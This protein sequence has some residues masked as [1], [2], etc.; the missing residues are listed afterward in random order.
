[1]NVQDLIADIDRGARPTYFFFWGHRA[2]GDSSVGKWCLSQ[3]WLAPFELDGVGYASAEHFM[4]AGKARL[5]GDGEALAAI[6]KAPDPAAAKKLGRGVRGFEDDVWRKHRHELVVTGNLAKFEQHPKLG[7]FLLSIR[8]DVIV[9][10]SPRDTIWGIGLGQE[11]PKARDPR[12][13]R[14]LNLLGFALMEVRERL[15][16]RATRGK[17]AT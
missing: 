5:F 11:N 10:A 9:E 15:R 7:F 13:W 16:K 8:E 14:G 4:M 6:L 1:M 12:L 2:S 3:W 17:G